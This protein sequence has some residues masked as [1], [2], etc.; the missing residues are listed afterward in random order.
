MIQRAFDD[1]LKICG[2]FSESPVFSKFVL[3]VKVYRFDAS[4][5]VRREATMD[6]SVTLL[7][8]ATGATIWQDRHRVHR[9]E[10]S[11]LALDVGVLASTDDLRAVALRAMSEAVDVLLGKPEF[12]AAFR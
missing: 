9:V 10:G 1:G 5:F 12:R 2:L 4:Q 6:F 11:S 3:V 7:N 8:R